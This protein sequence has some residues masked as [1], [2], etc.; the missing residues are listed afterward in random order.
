MLTFDSHKREMC[1]YYLKQRSNECKYF[2][3]RAFPLVTQ[4]TYSCWN[5]IRCQ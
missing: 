3:K 1:V 2:N 5:Y 4:Q